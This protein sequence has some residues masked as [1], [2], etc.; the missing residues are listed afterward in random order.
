MLS[1]GMR[2]LSERGVSKALGGSRPGSHWRRQR[3]APEGAPYAPVFIS[4]PNLVPYTPASL[5]IALAQPVLYRATTGGIGY[6]VDA[7]LL[8]EICEVWLKAR[9]AGALTHQQELTATTAE[10]LMSALA[11]VGIVALVDEATGYQEV[12]DRNELQRILEAYISKELLPWTRCFPDDFY[13][14]MFRLRGWEYSPPQPKRPKFVGKLTNELV[15]E[16]LPHGVV[17]ELKRKNPVVRNGW[18]GYKHHQFL[19]EDIGHPHLQNQLIAVTTLMRAAPTWGS[20]KRLFDRAFPGPQSTLPG[21]ED[22]DD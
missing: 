9:R 15:Y 1:D 10:V 13:R 11:H 20:F 19:T 22:D 5:R 2:L 17:E 14:E 16:R 12:R 8:P 21:F 18:R 4:A 6:G 3:A 7:T